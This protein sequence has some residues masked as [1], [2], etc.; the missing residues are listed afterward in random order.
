[1]KSAIIIGVGAERGL[2]GALCR[3][4]AVEG[5]HVIAAGRT[6]TKLAELAETIRSAGGRITPIV[7]DAATTEGIVAA[8]DAAERVSGR[9][10]ELVVYN[11]GVSHDYRNM[12]DMDDAFF[13]DLWKLGCFG[14][15][16]TGREAA[17]RMLPAGGTVIFTGATASIRSKP[18]FMALASS[19][20]ALRAVAFGMAREFG[21]E[22]LHVA[23]V[24]LDGCIDGDELNSRYPQVKQK[25]SA[26]GMLQPEALAEAYWMLHRQP[27]S[28]WTL[29][30]DLRPSRE[31]F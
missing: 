7:I 10:P 21:R 15:F 12:R 29:E 6:E 31:S 5:L 19:K 9:A 23:H 27:A 8:F 30:L 26:D 11:A 14:G 17:R 1:M 25:L 22:G 4:C 28:A 24:I 13:E 20:A 2:G 18:P 16:A 3:R